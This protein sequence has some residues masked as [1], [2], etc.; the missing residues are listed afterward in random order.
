MSTD[1]RANFKFVTETIVKATLAICG[2]LMTILLLDMREDV[3]EQG[4]D[5]KDTKKEISDMRERMAAVEVYVK[6]KK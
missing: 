4:V 5:I 1:Q 3:K 2:T 6:L